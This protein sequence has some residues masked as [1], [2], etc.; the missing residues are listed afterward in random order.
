MAAHRLSG[1]CASGHQ[2]EEDERNDRSQGCHQNGPQEVAC[3]PNA[4]EE[5]PYLL[6]P[7]WLRYLLMLVARPIVPDLT[8]P[9]INA[10]WRL[11]KSR[12]V[13]RKGTDTHSD[14]DPRIRPRTSGKGPYGLTGCL[15]NPYSRLTLL[16]HLL[17][18]I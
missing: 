15:P 12:L 8:S 1:R 7:S 2:P 5:V 14:R 6:Y 16:N 10:R 4:A 18:L 17:S 9:P 13:V 11:V 3:R